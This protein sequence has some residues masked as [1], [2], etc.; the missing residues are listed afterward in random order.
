MFI[1][2]I[3]LKTL[4]HTNHKSREI[5]KLFFYYNTASLVVIVDNYII[6]SCV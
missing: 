4:V 5:N 2:C 6:A 1:A 3:E